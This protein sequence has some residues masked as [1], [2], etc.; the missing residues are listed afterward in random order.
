MF[1]IQT[2][3]VDY[4]GTRRH[5][6]RDALLAVARL[7]GAELG[8]GDAVDAA[9]LARRHQLAAG[10]VEPVHVAWEG[11]LRHI[12]LW[13]EAAARDTLQL[14]LQL[15]SG[16]VRSWRA[17]AEPRAV[18]GLD[19]MPACRRLPLA[20]DLPL[21]Y[22]RLEIESAAG[23]FETLLIAAPRHASVP[24]ERQWGV[25]AP[26]YALC[27]ARSY[28]IG[29]FHDLGTLGAWAGGRGASFVATLPLLATFL[30]A[31][32]EPSPYSPASRLFWNELFLD[33]DAAARALGLPEAGGA[34]RLRCAPGELVDYRRA[35]AAKAQR[36]AALAREFHATG[37]RQ[38]PEFGRFLGAHP[39]AESY[40]RFRAAGERQR[41]GWQA[42]PERLRTGEIRAGDFDEDD[43]QRHLYA[44]YEAER[45]LTALAGRLR[46]AGVHLYLDLPLGV[47]G[48]GYDVWRHPELFALGA[49]AGAPPDALFGGGQSWGFPPLRPDALRRNGYRYLIDCIRHHLRCAGMLRLDHVMA[50]RRLYW[51]PPGFSARDGVYVRYPAD[52]WL[53]VL[54]LE[55]QRHH[56]TIIGEDLGTVPREVR[57][58]MDRHKLQRMFVV[59]F[60]ASAAEPPLPAVPQPVVASLNTH[61]MPPFAAYWRALDVADQHELGMTAEDEKSARER[62][63]ASTRRAITRQLGLPPAAAEPDGAGPALHGLLEHLAASDARAVLIS[64]EDLWLE[65]RPQNVPGTG[66]ERPN[67]RRRL[68]LS[69]EELTRDRN[70]AAALDAVARRRNGR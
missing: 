45:Q 52:E 23:T 34:E 8:D 10:G 63:R 13:H 25:F 65:T 61:D 2:W 9:I 21:G 59:Q 39:D 68:R 19:A 49:S 29:D 6:E 15:E 43:A 12:D 42:W 58:A 64:L 67:W 60:E 27:S 28:G 55:S 62:G 30:T 46:D 36:L 35:A 37:G 47:H 24:T 48:D 57:K 4:C 54:T 17:A 32:F 41:A 3:Y 66:A 16:E 5:A 26:V 31:P 40:A 7:L 50:L 70:I 1:G 56:A 33:L 53:A 44:Q 22:H 18:R 51:V 38:R 20:I 69:L 11:R 14:H